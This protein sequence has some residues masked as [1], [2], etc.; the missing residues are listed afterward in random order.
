M[1]SRTT[2]RLVIPIAVFITQTTLLGF[3]PKYYAIHISE[4]AQNNALKSTLTLPSS[5]YKLH[6]CLRSQW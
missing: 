5:A 2:S 3:I 4:M 6:L 1:I